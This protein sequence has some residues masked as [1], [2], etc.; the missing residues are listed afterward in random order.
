MRAQAITNSKESVLRKTR[1][2]SLLSLEIREISRLGITQTKHFQCWAQIR[3]PLTK[4]K[5]HPDSFKRI[6]FPWQVKAML[7]LELALIGTSLMVVH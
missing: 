7:K 6:N 1:Q 3:G 4:S 5:N 2:A